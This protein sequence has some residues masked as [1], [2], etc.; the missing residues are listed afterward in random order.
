MNIQELATIRD[1]G[2]NIKVAVLNNGYLGMVRQWQQFFHNRRYSSTPMTGPD[3]EQFAAA[4]GLAGKTVHPGG[5]IES[6]VEWANETE[7]FAIV[8]FH[9]DSEANVYPMIPSGM[10]VSEM[11]EEHA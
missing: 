8:D 3:Y 5:D 4:Y 7:G 9:I 1:M 6:A 10:S 11:I 2:L